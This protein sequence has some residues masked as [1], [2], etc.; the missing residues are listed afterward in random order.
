MKTPGIKIYLPKE[1][2]P[3]AYTCGEQWFFNTKFWKLYVILGI[4]W[5]DTNWAKYGLSI[6]APINGRKNLDDICNKLDNLGIKYS[7][8]MSD[9]NWVYRVKISGRKSNL[10]IIDAIYNQYTKDTMKNLKGFYIYNNYFVDKE[11]KENS[12][13]KDKGLEIL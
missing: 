13:L 2:N 1:N 6:F 4:D 3:K 12:Y 5:T 7:I 8:E 11:Y 10:I 9:S